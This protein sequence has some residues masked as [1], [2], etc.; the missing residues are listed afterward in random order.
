MRGREGGG[1]EGATAQNHSVLGGLGVCAAAV[2]TSL[3]ARPHGRDAC[4]I[5]LLAQ[6]HEE[7]VWLDVA[8][9]EAAR[10]DKLNTRELRCACVGGGQMGG[11]DEHTSLS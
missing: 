10:M 7:V 4:L 9:D 11:A 1:K 2:Q 8:V 6:T 5:G 3:A